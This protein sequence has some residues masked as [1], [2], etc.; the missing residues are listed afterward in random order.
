MAKRGGSKKDQDRFETVETGELLEGCPVRPLGYNGDSYFVSDTAGQIRVLRPRD[1]QSPSMILSLFHGDDAWLRKECPTDSR[2]AKT[3]Q[4]RVAWH[5]STAEGR[6]MRACLREGFFD[7]GKH[8]RG[9]GIWPFSAEL[10]VGEEFAGSEQLVIHT[11]DKVGWVTYGALGPVIDWMKAGIKLGEFVYPSTAPQPAPGD[12]SAAVEEIDD[13]VAAFGR[14]PWKDDAETVCQLL[15]GHVSCQFIPAAIPH[16]PGAWV[17]GRSGSGKSTLLTFL[18]NLTQGRALRYENA[19]AAGLRDDFR[20][21]NEARPVYINEAES[22]EDNRRIQNLIEM[23]RYVYDVDEGAYRR[24]GSQGSSHNPTTIFV[25][26]AVEPPPLLPQDANRIA[27]LR[28]GKLA[29]TSEQ[30]ERFDEEMPAKARALA[31]KLARRVIEVYPLFPQAFAAFRKGLLEKEHTPRTANTFG[32]LLAAAH[33]VQFGSVP[34]DSDV[35]EW[36]SRL[37]GR[38]LA[39]REDY[40]SNEDLCL[41]HLCTTLI[42][43]FRSGEQ[44]PI[45]EFIR[46]HLHEKDQAAKGVLRKFGLSIVKCEM[47]GT[48]VKTWLAVAN[49]HQALDGIFKG[50]RWA[51]GA[52][53]TPLRQLEGAAPSRHSYGFEGKACRATLIPASHFPNTVNAGALFD[54]DFDIIGPGGA[55]EAKHG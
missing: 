1:L 47:P 30:M 29:V 51:G 40:Q 54:G 49:N 45:G 31:P 37:D 6:I 17:Q 8:V 28:L 26:A 14:W 12:E 46:K 5:N 33:I 23:A 24:G 50:T 15:L 43:P 27:M 22:S 3:G 34:D 7:T 2:R 55:A 53:I 35:A 11:G 19:T 38:L 25:F 13:L 36:A 32:V 18:K 16:R 52:W 21:R 39:S 41:S 44:T 42:S 9:P 10:M 48:D 4:S 20:E